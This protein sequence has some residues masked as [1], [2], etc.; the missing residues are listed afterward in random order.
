MK[1][2][3]SI[4]IIIFLLFWGCINL[5]SIDETT[6]LQNDTN[7]S[8]IDRVQ[9]MTGIVLWTDNEYSYDYK[10]SISL[11]Y[12]YCPYN[13]IIS[14]TEGSYNWAWLESVLDNISS[15]NHQAIIRFY[16]VYPGSET[17][18]P[19]YI[20]AIPGY[21]EESWLVENKETWFP[22]W[23]NKELQDFTTEFYSE[24][25]SRYN[26]DPRIAF[27][28][29][30]F[31]LWGEYHIYEHTP[32][33]YVGDMLGNVFPSKSYQNIFIDHLNTEFTE[34]QWSISIDAS[35]TDYTNFAST[36]NQDNYGLFDDSFMHKDHELSGN[37]V[38]WWDLLNHDSRNNKFPAG[39]EISYYKDSDQFNAL[40][41]DG[42]YGR[43]FAQQC[44]EYQISYMI[45]NDTI[46]Y[47]NKI[48]SKDE[49]K[50]A[51]LLTG[52]KFEITE[53]L[54]VGDHREITVK[55]LGTAPIYY[56]AYLKV[57]GVI[58]GNSLKGLSADKSIVCTLNT[59]SEFN[60]VIVCNRI[61]VDQEITYHAADGILISSR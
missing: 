28:Q 49:I 30:G 15:R 45:G 10:D 24:L 39:G 29:V 38:D 55:N 53:D 47:G 6:E 56:H 57:D 60:P 7:P 46:E 41:P 12:K 32:Y 20:K 21:V 1:I 52:Y 19:N 26:N 8:L 34:L 5:T 4:L 14:D 2:N 25:A 35:D 18:V 13:E 48:R 36:A 17:T 44:K 27:L 42:L 43:T 16:Y 58:S 61:L 9:P 11:E 3:N 59:I 54:I 40:N 31:G 22:D 37:N 51:S 50:N 33:N 23:S